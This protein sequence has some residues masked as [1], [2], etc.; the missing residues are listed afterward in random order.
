MA[1]C[2]I[3]L[4][5]F[6]GPFAS[7]AH[8]GGKC[9]AL[10]TNVNFWSVS[11]LTLQFLSTAIIPLLSPG[12]GAACPDLK[13]FRKS[14]NW[15]AFIP[16]KAPP[17]LLLMIPPLPEVETAGMRCDNTLDLC[18]RNSADVLGCSRSAGP[19]IAVLLPDVPM[20]WYC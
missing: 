20:R 17:V 14:W 3:F 11:K 5:S 19:K 1:D 2:K 16:A 13:T 18:C 4:S 9:D 15:V 7:A 12:A 10:V 8:T 6:L